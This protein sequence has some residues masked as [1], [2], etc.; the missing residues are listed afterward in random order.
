[1][2]KPLLLLPAFA[3]ARGLTAYRWFS[4]AA[5]FLAHESAGLRVQPRDVRQ[6]ALNGT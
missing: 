5:V 1:M 2:K 3:A 6:K 4:Q